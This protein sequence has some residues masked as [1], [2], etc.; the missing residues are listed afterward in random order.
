[1][2]IKKK[3]GNRIKELRDQKHLS[4][5]ALA[6]NADIDRKYLSDVELGKRNVSILLVSQIAK[7]LDVTLYDIFN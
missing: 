7:G 1:M 4:Q 2:D 5:E 6:F 3:L